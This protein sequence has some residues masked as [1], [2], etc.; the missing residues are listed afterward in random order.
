MSLMSWDDGLDVGVDAMN[1]EHK[2][3]L[4][5]MNAL[6]DAVQADAP[7]A[8][9]LAKLAALKAATVEHF[10]HEEAYM[11]EIGFPGAPGHKLI[12]KDLLEKLDAHAAAAEAS[13]G[14]GLGD[15]LFNFLRFWLS[16]HIR[17]VDVKYGKGA[18]DAA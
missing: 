7:G 13:G 6:Y 17:G 16:A 9:V 14:E 4:S 15:A 8:D 2:R 1:A 10:A 5:L 3:L 18:A 11:D 12:H